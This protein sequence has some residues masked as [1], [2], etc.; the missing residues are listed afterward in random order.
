MSPW[1]RR[2][3]GAR[4]GPAAA[5]SRRLRCPGAGREPRQLLYAARR[6][7]GP[8]ALGAAAAPLPGRQPLRRRLRRP[9]PRLGGQRSAAPLSRRLRRQGRGPRP[10]ERRHP[11]AAA[12]PGV[13]RSPRQRRAPAAGAAVVPAGPARPRRRACR[14]PPVGGLPAGPAWGAARPAPAVVRRAGSAGA[15]APVLRCLCPERNPGNDNA[16]PEGA[17][18]G[19]CQRA[20]GRLLALSRRLSGSGGL[21]ATLDL[22]PV[23]HVEELGDVVRA[24]V[25]ERK[26]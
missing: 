15:G 25:L 13:S 5:R 9:D 3:G 11:P 20:A 2:P 26:S 21:V 16:A 22:V 4:P 14:G 6:A 17:A 18:L 12:A 8:G 23:D 10:G 1:W 7:S 24:L 19:E